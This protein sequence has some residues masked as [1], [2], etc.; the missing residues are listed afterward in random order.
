MLV[1][2][3]VQLMS[4]GS[5]AAIVSAED[6]FVVESV[7]H[8]NEHDEQPEELEGSQSGTRPPKKCRH[9][10]IWNYFID[11]ATDPTSAICIVCKNPY[12]HSNNT[13]NLS[14]VRLTHV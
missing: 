7:D 1:Y 11:D 4:D 13:S 8:V 6:L 3:K 12:Q 2:G 14:K 10:P 5:M 9:S